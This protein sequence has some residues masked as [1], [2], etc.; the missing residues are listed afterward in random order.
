MWFIY[1][2]LETLS[3]LLCLNSPKTENRFPWNSTINFDNNFIYSYVYRKPTFPTN[4][5]SRR[6][7]WILENDLYYQKL[8][9]QQYNLARWELQPKL[10]YYTIIRCSIDGSGE[11]F[12]S[13]LNLCMLHIQI[14]K[15][16]VYLISRYES[17]F[18]ITINCL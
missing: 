6:Y 11:E 16:T 15:P 4:A 9:H 13:Y 18:I 3:E 10:R 2:F 1:N 14:Y 17:Q 12:Y 5:F 7:S 8:Q